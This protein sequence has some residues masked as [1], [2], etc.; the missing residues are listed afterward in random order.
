[1]KR[2]AGSILGFAVLLALVASCNH[3]LLKDMRSYNSETESREPIK[4]IEPPTANPDGSVEGFQLEDK[5]FNNPDAGGFSNKVFDSLMLTATFDDEVPSYTLLQGDFWQSS[6]TSKKEY[7]HVNAPSSAIQNMVI[8]NVTYYQYRG[9]NPFYKA[10]SS[11]NTNLLKVNDTEIEK[12][13]RF[14]FYRMTGEIGGI[15]PIDRGLVAI[16]TWSKLVFSFAENNKPVDAENTPFYMFDPIGYVSKVGDNYNLNL[17]DW[18]KAAK[19][20][21]TRRTKPELDLITEA[22]TA[23]AGS[24][25][26]NTTASYFIHNLLNLADKHFS[27]NNENGLITYTYSISPDGK[28]IIRTAEAYLGLQ[29]VGSTEKEEYEIGEAT[30]ALHSSITIN[31]KEE[32]LSLSFGTSPKLAFSSSGEDGTTYQEAAVG[33]PAG[34]SF[35]ALIHFL[36][37]EGGSFIS[38]E[39]KKYT[40]KDKGMIFVAEGKEVTYTSSTDSTTATY[41]DFQLSL[42]LENLPSLTISTA[43]NKTTAFLTSGGGSSTQTPQTFKYL[44][45]GKTFT[46]RLKD[47]NDYGTTLRSLHIS[48]D[49]TVL[50]K[51]TTWP[52]ETPKSK[53]LG[54]IDDA[55]TASQDSG[56]VAG[57]QATY[58]KDRG[59]LTINGVEYFAQYDDKGPSFVKRIEAGY[60]YRQG[61]TTYVFTDVRILSINGASSHSLAKDEYAS[62]VYGEYTVQVSDNRETLTITSEDGTTIQATLSDESIQQETFR[63]KVKGKTFSGRE[64]DEAGL[65]TLDFVSYEFN[66]DGTLA[67][68]RTRVWPSTMQSSYLDFTV[69]NGVEA[70]Q[71]SLKQS[72]GE[73]HSVTLSDD[74]TTITVDGKTYSETT[75][76][77][78]APALAY[79]LLG[80]SFGIR[81]RLENGNYCDY[82][83]TYTFGETVG[84]GSYTKTFWEEGKAATEAKV[85]ISDSTID[86]KT[87]SL[88][89]S[90]EGAWKLTIGDVVYQENYRDPMPRPPAV[91]DTFFTYVKGK[92]FGL[93][94]D[95]VYT[96]Y[97][98]SNDVETDKRVTVATKVW[99]SDLQTTTVSVTVAEGDHYKASIDGKEA[100]YD[101]V[102]HT[103]TVNGKDYILGYKDPGPSLKLKLSGNTYSRRAENDLGAGLVLESY[104]FDENGNGNYQ[105]VIWQQKPDGPKAISIA[106]NSAGHDTIDGKIATLD[107]A[108][109]FIAGSKYLLNYADQGPSFLNRVKGATYSGSGYTYTFSEDGKSISCSNE[110]TY[111]FAQADDTMRAVYKAADAVYWG[112]RLADDDKTLYWSGSSWANPGTTPTDG[113]T[114]SP[115]YRGA[116]TTPPEPEPEPEAVTFQSQVAGR[117]FSVR[118]KDSSGKYTKELKTYTFNQDGTSATFHTKNWP[119]TGATGASTSYTV[120]NGADATTGKL[121]GNGQTISVS[122]AA[123]SNTII[124]SDETYYV[125]YDSIDE[126]PHLTYKLQGKEFS[127]RLTDSQNLNTLELETYSFGEVTGSGTYRKDTW[128]KANPETSSV[129]VTDSTVDGKWA[130]LDISTKDKWKLTI[131]DVVYQENYTDPTPSFLYRVKG[132]PSYKSKDGSTIYTFSNDGKNLHFMSGN[133]EYNYTYV[134]DKGVQDTVVYAAYHSDDGW[135]GFGYAGFALYNNDGQIKATYSSAAMTGTIDWNS[136]S[137]EADLVK[138]NSGNFLDNVENSMYSFRPTDNNGNGLDL[139]TWKFSADGSTATLIKTPWKKAGTTEVT[140]MSIFD[141]VNNGLSG[142]GDGI[143]F[144]LSEN[145]STLTVGGSQTSAANGTFSLNYA[146]QGPSFLN[147]VKGATYKNGITEYKFSEDGRSIDLT[148]V[149]WKGSTVKTTYTY[150]EGKE[151]LTDISARYSGYLVQL[152]DNENLIKH[153]T[154]PNVTDATSIMQWPAYRQT[155][156]TAKADF[157][158]TVAGATFIA[159]TESETGV[160]DLDLEIYTFSN[161]GSTV[162]HRKENWYSGSHSVQEYQ[163]TNGSTTTAGTLD[164]LGTATLDLSNTTLSVKGK[165]YYANYTDPTPSFINRVKNRWYTGNQCE[166]VF[167]NDGKTLYYYEYGSFKSKYTYSSPSP[168]ENVDNT[169]ANYNGWRSKFFLE[170]TEK[171]RGYNLDYENLNT[172]YDAT[173]KGTAEEAKAAGF[174]SHP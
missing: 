68:K 46:T 17:F 128:L 18:Y 156:I 21:K 135:S 29:G 60:A 20:T 124:I 115:A 38:E 127:V 26:D 75:M 16:D 146:D 160:Y 59:V 88:D 56:W 138:D 91:G 154:V 65:H 116:S 79:Q 45:R 87:A 137:Y 141:K 10:D 107:D 64:Q 111:T 30:D 2:Q 44:L 117:A 174:S 37:E 103:L 12:L 6:D 1:M 40:F 89:T 149:D 129:A 101:P 57:K 33:Q 63:K 131:G 32:C 76:D 15:D 25:F 105:R 83:E 52:S 114:S 112:L 58:H 120:E 92:S 4:T 54:G 61:E 43:G 67:T 23:I 70:T 73:V 168:S 121:S 165:T 130:S 27:R 144:T 66:E 125:G 169:R 14:Y 162:T 143:S 41:G 102:S 24:P 110:K 109:L 93:R 72:G 106:V 81:P 123:E 157:R 164:A 53:T 158:S 50:E 3:G 55:E 31:G 104:S 170:D 71:G 140:V 159:R 22:A 139:Y 13:S 151:N 62:A 36:I 132:N 90:I 7:I 78:P 113:I 8:S 133:K 145:L 97:Q 99:P 94:E 148:Y 42:S 167:S 153:S 82:L 11:Y 69:E 173:Y 155:T 100:T 134:E 172:N 51:T 19:D 150:E 5:W 171:G 98:F 126:G 48:N 108:T 142:A 118:A 161:D 49:G 166:Y 80:R 77:E 28:K 39:E 136:L 86:N 9:L 84:E 152:Y 163:V 74:A 147:R 119:N 122:Y 85:V 96:E 34:P 95:K 35:Q 47:G